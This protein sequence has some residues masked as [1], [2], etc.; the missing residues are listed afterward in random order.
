MRASPCLAVLAAILPA[1]PA[2]A[3]DADLISV[4]VSAHPPEEVEEHA[5]MTG[6]TLALLAPVDADGD[7][8][9]APGEL[10]RSSAA[11]ELGVWDQMPLSAGE[12]R[13]ERRSTAA[14]LREGYVELTARFRCPEGDLHQTF[15]MLSIL[16][17]GYRVVV[18]SGSGAK[19]ADAQHQQVFIPDPA[20]AGPGGPGTT[21][22]DGLFGWIRLGVIHIFTGYDHLAFLLALL[23]VGQTWRRVLLMVTAFTVAHSITLAVAAL[24]LVPISSRAARWVEV[25]IAASVV[26]VAAENLILSSHRHR[27][28]ITF[29]FGLIHGFGFASVLRGYGLGD[30]VVTGLFGFNLGVELGQAFVVAL[31]FPLVL[32]LSRRPRAF[33]WSI[34]LASVAIAATGG[35]WL[36]DR[37]Q[38]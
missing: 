11:L 6:G 33:T 12:A 30:A 8:A 9:L 10:E 23:L 17:S 36:V 34:R 29:G 19:L 26:Y 14:A 35:Y 3:H 4:R 20:V 13:C 2:L 1:F 5:T 28:A 22:I 27:A 37:L 16:P 24:E 25:L 7:G 38:G 15:R 32:W 21:R 31:V 18:E